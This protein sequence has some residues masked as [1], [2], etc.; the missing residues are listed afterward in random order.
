MKNKLI[1]TIIVVA[2]VVVC[3][4]LGKEFASVFKK[5]RVKPV[6]DGMVIKEFKARVI[7]FKESK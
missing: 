3:G 1:S 4:F 6:L 7:S 2:I 5:E